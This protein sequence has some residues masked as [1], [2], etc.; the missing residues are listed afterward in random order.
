MDCNFSCMA[1]QAVKA[2][3]APSELRE[4]KATGGGMLAMVHLELACVVKDE[5]TRATPVVS[6]EMRET[7]GMPETVDF[8]LYFS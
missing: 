8:S 7:V 2:A 1:K 6:A 3:M 5:D 4:H